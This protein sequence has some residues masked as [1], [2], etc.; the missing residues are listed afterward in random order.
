MV[1]LFLTIAFS[2]IV[3]GFSKVMEVTQPV[4]TVVK[5][6]GA[7]NFQCGFTNTEDASKL[8]ITLLKQE[9]NESVQIC[10][11]SFPLEEGSLF[12]TNEDGIQCQIH[13]GRESVN[14]TLWGLKATDA[15]LYVCQM[16]WIYP[17]PYYSVLGSGTQLFL[18]ERDACPAVYPYFWISVM[19]AS[20]LLGYSILITIY[21][22]TKVLRKSMYFTPGIYEKIIPM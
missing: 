6:Q 8:R 12:K 2:S 5:S 20:G 18:L 19:I 21:M 7:A 11:L 16:E 3:A 14:I 1:A 10:A 22:K 4:F 13:P 15:G 9:G 17:P